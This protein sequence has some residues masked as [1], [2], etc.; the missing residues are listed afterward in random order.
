[1]KRKKRSKIPPQKTSKLYRTI[2][3]LADGA[4]L[5]AFRAHP[6]YLTDKGRTKNSR[7]SIV[8]RVTGTVV[9]F[10]EESTKGRSRQALKREAGGL[11][12]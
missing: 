4:V 10:V 7:A 8:K 2:W 6:E 3:R 1:M 11:Q 9:G 12:Q 5:D